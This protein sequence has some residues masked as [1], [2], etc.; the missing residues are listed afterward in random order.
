MVGVVWACILIFVWLLGKI[1]VVEWCCEV[2]G[3][4]EV[5][6]GCKVQFSTSSQPDKHLHVCVL[7]CVETDMIR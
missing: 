1:W 4:C 7:V 5:Q 2:V 3:S 6:Q